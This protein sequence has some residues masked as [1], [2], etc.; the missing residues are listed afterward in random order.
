MATKK[1]AAPKE[2]KVG[3]RVKY[4]NRNGD[5]LPGR[6]SAV[7][8]TQTG[9]LYTVEATVTKKVKARSAQLKGF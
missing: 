3:A 7:K 5:T 6:V 9:A 8:Q 1:T 4:T 2:Y